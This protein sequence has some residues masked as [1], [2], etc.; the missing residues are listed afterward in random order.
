L[1]DHEAL[2]DP[3]VRRDLVY[4]ARASLEPVA[5]R[6]GGRCVAVAFPSGHGDGAYR[7][8]VGF[9]ADRAVAVATDF[10]VLYEQV[11][12]TV[13]FADLRRYRRGE[14]VVPGAP[15]LRMRFET[16]DRRTWLRVEGRAEVGWEAF[17]ITG[18][19]IAARRGP[20]RASP[21]HVT[22]IDFDLWSALPDDAALELELTVG[23]RP[24]APA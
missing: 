17:W 11:T 21:E 20:S 5:V 3:S 16:F 13:R 7:S 23:A 22:E 12:L 1:A 18:D 8:F 24:L 14:L 2:E 15:W 19:R 4:G 9:M 10:Q 6:S